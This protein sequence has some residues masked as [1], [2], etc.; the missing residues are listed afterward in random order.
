MKVEIFK[1]NF[2]SYKCVQH[3]L[4]NPIDAYSNPVVTESEVI[5]QSSPPT[6][7]HPLFIVNKTTT[8]SETYLENYGNPMCTINKSHTMIV[9]ERTGDKVAIKLFYGN[10]HRRAGNSWFKVS[11]NV[12]YI[13]VNTKTG[14]VYVGHL[15]EYQK[16]KKCLK[17]VRRNFFAQC[18][19]NDMKMMIKNHLNGYRGFS[20]IFD[21]ATQAISSFMFEVDGRDD[22]ENLDFGQRLFRFYLNKRQIRYP[23]NFHVYSQHLVGPEIR[24]ELKKN[25]NRLVDAF[26][27][28]QN[29]SGKKLKKS[30]HT[31]RGLNISL[32]KYA[33]GMFG[34]DWLNQDGEVITELLNSSNTV[35]LSLPV[36]FKSVIGADE[37][38]RV[39]TIFKKVYIDGLM[40]TWSFQDHIRMYTELKLYGEIDIRWQ[41]EYSKDD[42]RQEHLD[43]TEK[44]QFYKDGFYQR[45]YPKYF[46]NKIQNKIGEYQLILLT[47]SRGYNE[48]SSTQSNCVKTY[49]GKASSFI[50]SIRNESNGDRATIEY[51]LTKKDGNVIA[52]RIQGLGRFNNR[53]EEE[54]DDVLFKLDDVVLSSVKDK[55]FE[56][57]KI[58]KEC[59]NGKVL[60]SDSFWEDDKLKWVYKN[61]DKTSVN[62]WEFF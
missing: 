29:L 61:I 12:E 45:K 51:G 36:E 35:Q 10:R 28:R 38:R 17:R 44:I 58:E 55:R 60:T 5:H 57:V 7:K 62:D 23:N 47:D 56:T 37:L 2:E 11:W 19:I 4:F 34:D 9:V 8:D 20:E 31:C 41:S 54:W 13:T 43:W 27:F 22:F 40:D 46:V 50:V 53:L 32:Y 15:R 21:V 26:M 3:R 24:K 18:P 16:K 42:F 25:G 59:K 1:Q 39:Y 6:K 52:T 49:V 48:E 33:R 14:D 30:L